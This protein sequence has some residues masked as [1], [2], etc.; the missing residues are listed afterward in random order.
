MY[1]NSFFSGEASFGTQI[2]LCKFLIICIIQT[3]R[4]VLFLTYL[5]GGLLHV[6]A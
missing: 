6:L 4:N 2:M 5:D 1:S 3:F